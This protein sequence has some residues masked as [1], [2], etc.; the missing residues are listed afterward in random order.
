MS[1]ASILA[2]ICA[3]ASFFVGPGWGFLLAVVAIIAGLIGFV[4]SLSPRVRGGVTSFFAIVA[5][6]IGIVT[7]IV[8]LAV[9][10]VS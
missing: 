8:K 7:A 1:G 9:G 6:L 4:V 10:V 2:L 3:L 5:G